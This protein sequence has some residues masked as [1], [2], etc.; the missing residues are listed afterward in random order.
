MQIDL[1]GNIINEVTEETVK[2]EKPSPFTFTNAISNKQYPATMDGYNAFLTNLS[3]SQRND[4]IF[5]AN[6]MNKYHALGD[7][8]QF[9]FYYHAMPKKKYF[10]KWAKSTE[11]KYLKDVCEYYQ[12]STKVGKEYLRS[13][14]ENNLK[15]IAEY[16]KNKH[17]GKR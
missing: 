5:Y 14:T 17:G 16:N 1:F 8:E 10:A 11:E 2:V 13:L 3:F 15:E 7:K 12:V 9:D 6:E 4:T